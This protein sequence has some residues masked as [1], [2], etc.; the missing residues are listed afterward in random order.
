MDDLFD[1]PTVIPA[2]TQATSNDNDEQ[3]SDGEDGALDWAK[4]A[5]STSLQAPVIPKRGE[6]D[7]EPKVGSN[8]QA[9]SLQRARDAML[10][11]LRATHGISK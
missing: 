1:K 7:Y 11:V 10:G 2:G 4:L 5:G 8:L 3:S 6:K 9:H